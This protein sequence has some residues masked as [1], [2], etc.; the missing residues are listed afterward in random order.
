MYIK[1]NLTENIIEDAK[2][3]PVIAILGPRQ[4]GK[5]TVAREAFPQHTYVSLE[6][7]DV[8]E[9]ATADPRTFLKDHENEHGIILAEVQHV[10]TLLSYIQTSVDL[11]RRPGYYILTGSQNFL[12]NQAITQ[13][14]AGRISIHTLLPLSIE[15]LKHAG[16][17]PETSEKTILNGFYP[18]IYGQDYD[19]TKWYRDYLRTYVERD[20]RTLGKVEDLSVFVRFLKLCAGRIGQPVNFASLADDAG[21]SPT[22]AKAWLSILEASYIIFLLQPH[23]KNFS[24]RLVKTPKIFFFDPGL[25]CNLLGI[26]DEKQLQTHY[27]RGGLFETMM[28][29]D[30]HKQYYNMDRTPHVYFWGDKHHEVDCIIEQADQL[31]PIEIKAGQT[32][33]GSYFSGLTHWNSLA[34]ADPARGFVIYAGDTNSTRSAGNVIGWRQAGMLINK[35]RTL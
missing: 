32:I 29:S 15:E 20:V 22:T 30:L 28:I 2:K 18:I 10:P 4:S 19:P 16:K 3:A 31:F 14:L 12:V 11:N 13:T 9:F 24:K 5:T 23:Y 7:Y 8:R 35:I 27:L 33:S 21:I 17:L 1:R 6:D 26:E 25:A 34:D